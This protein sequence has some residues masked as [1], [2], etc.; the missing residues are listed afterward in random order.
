MN[1]ALE[2][3]LCMAVPIVKDLNRI[4][5]LAHASAGLVG[6]DTV[7]MRYQPG[8]NRCFDLEVFLERE[9]GLKTRSGAIG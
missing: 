9:R 7:T 1:I 8:G 3:S 2:S 4:R 6:R 5:I